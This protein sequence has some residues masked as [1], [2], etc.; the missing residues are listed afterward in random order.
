M[1]QGDYVLEL[2]CRLEAWSYL[3]SAQIRKPESSEELEAGGTS[4]M[5]VQNTRDSFEHTAEELF[6]GLLIDESDAV[7]L[8][9]HHYCFTAWM[10]NV[11]DLIVGSI[12]VWK[13]PFN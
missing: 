5:Y 11:S 3:S 12:V 7:C 6:G 10:D 4:P 9:K 2:P 8:Q 1:Q 13:I